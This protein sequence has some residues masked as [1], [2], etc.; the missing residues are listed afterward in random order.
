MKRINLV[1]L[2]FSLSTVIILSESCKKEESC[3]TI[4]CNISIIQQ[5]LDDGET[6]LEIFESNNT[7]LDSL[8]GKMYEGGLIFYLNAA[9]GTGMVTATLDQ[10]TGT[11][12]GCYGIDIAN[13][14]NITSFL[15]PD[16]E[17]EEGA[18]IGD[19]MANTTAILAGCMDNGIA[20]KLCRSIGADWFL[21]SR[22]ELNLMYTNLYQNGHGGF[23]SNHRYW[24]STEYGHY[25]AWNQAFANGS[26]DYSNKDYSKLV[27][28]VRAF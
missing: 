8:Y 26:Q 23:V 27:R 12:W 22:G 2:L 15:V 21:P 3:P 28:A 6:P 9:D 5:R 7:L 18:R 4:N 24:S 25:L 14:P 13:L 1:H 16:P 19:G 10:S 11:G 20:A 17:T